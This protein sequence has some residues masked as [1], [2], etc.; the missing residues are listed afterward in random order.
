MHL[1][2]KFTW[3]HLLWF[4][5]F[6]VALLQFGQAIFIERPNRFRQITIEVWVVQV[7]F[8][9]LIVTDDPR[10]HG[11]LCQILERTI[12]QTGNRWGVVNDI[13]RFCRR[14]RR[15]PIQIQQIIVVRYDPILPFQGHTFG[16]GVSNC[17]SFL[18][19]NLF[20]EFISFTLIAEWGVQQMLLA[21]LRPLDFQALGGG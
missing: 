14:P 1:K 18:L 13:L 20:I 12:G 9:G 17:D 7:N 2:S 5:H 15:A 19:H 6:F 11:I 3:T 8:T 10:K 21:V 4:V 16:F